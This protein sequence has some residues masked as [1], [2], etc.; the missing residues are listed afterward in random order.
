MLTDDWVNKTCY[1]FDRFL[2]GRRQTP[3]TPQMWLLTLETRCGHP[4]PE[5]RGSSWAARNNGLWKTAAGIDEP[6]ARISC[7]LSWDSTPYSSLD[8]RLLLRHSCHTVPVPAMSSIQL[9]IPA[10]EPL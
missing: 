9:Q 7:P 10:T 6:L 8:L 2:G 5:Y 1:I 3:P 4:L